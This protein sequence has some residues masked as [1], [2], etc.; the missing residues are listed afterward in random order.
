M[1]AVLPLSWHECGT[2]LGIRDGRQTTW[3]RTTGACQ[4]WPN[5][6]AN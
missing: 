3:M 6:V 5:S 4:V 1:T 2:L